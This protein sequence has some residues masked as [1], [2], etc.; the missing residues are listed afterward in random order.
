MNAHIEIARER[1]LDLIAE[2]VD[3]RA[4]AIA[5]IEC[6][7]VFDAEYSKRW[8]KPTETIGCKSCFGS[9]GK[10]VPISQK[11]SSSRTRVRQAW[12][13]LSGTFSPRNRNFCSSATGVS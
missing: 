5:A 8:I 3:A 11:L 2:G 7:D 10:L 12:R 6:A 9:G 1:F 4:A 13:S